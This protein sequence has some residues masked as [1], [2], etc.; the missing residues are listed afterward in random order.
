MDS[1]ESSSLVLKSAFSVVLVV[2]S[3][4]LFM[5]FLVFISSEPLGVAYFADGFSVFSI[6]LLSKKVF[7]Y[8]PLVGVSYHILF[9]T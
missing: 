1:T 5:I 6:N 8:L 9:Y 3:C 7:N 2:L 4:F